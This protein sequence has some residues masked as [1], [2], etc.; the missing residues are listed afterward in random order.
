MAKKEDFIR[1]VLIFLMQCDY[2]MWILTKESLKQ[3][4]RYSSYLISSFN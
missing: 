4:N 1:T 3:Q 2:K